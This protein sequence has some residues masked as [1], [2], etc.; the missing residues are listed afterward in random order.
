MKSWLF[1]LLFSMCNLAFAQFENR[2][3]LYTGIGV[4]PFQPDAQ[5]QTET[6]FQGYRSV[7]FFH[8]FLGYSVNRKFAMGGAFRQ[9][10]TAKDNYV[11]SNSM[12]GFGTKYNFIPFDKAISPFVYVDL[13]VNYTYLEQQQNTQ[14]V[15]QQ[16]TGNPQDINVNEI[17]IQEPE[18]QLAIFP[19]FSALLAVG[20]EFTIKRARKK[21]LGF[22]ILGGYSISNTASKSNV[23]ELFPR[24]DSQL[25]YPMV[26]AG[27]RF[28][29]L[30]RKSLY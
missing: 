10:L 9:L 6:V 13:G 7:P 24:N 21:N 27:L 22:F 1:L 14:T 15:P 19:S 26:C 4:V 23:T 17:T 2:L 5:I 30:Q 25:N 20:A 8:G 16:P 28:S 12:I 11:L 29:F 3:N 18:I